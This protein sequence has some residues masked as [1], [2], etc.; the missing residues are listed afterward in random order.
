M[1]TTTVHSEEAVP[2]PRR[3]TLLLQLQ[4][5]ALNLN[6]CRLYILSHRPLS[7]PPLT[8]RTGFWSGAFTTIGDGANIFTLAMNDTN[9]IWYYC[10]NL[11]HCESGMVGV[12]NPL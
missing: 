7:T 2:E 11:G 12:I 5:P 1:A 8:N 9:P 6:S 3:Q 10:A 4:G